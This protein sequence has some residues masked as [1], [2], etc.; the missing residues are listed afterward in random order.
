MLCKTEGSGIMRGDI[1]EEG[2][3]QPLKAFPSILL[4]TPLILISYDSL[5]RCQH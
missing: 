2:F 4:E 3:L 1:V 5:S